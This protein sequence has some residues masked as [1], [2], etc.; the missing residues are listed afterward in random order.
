MGRRT[1]MPTRASRWTAVT[2]RRVEPAV[3]GAGGMRAAR[4]SPAWAREASAL[5]TAAAARLA[6]VYLLTR[7]VHPQAYFR[8]AAARFL[9]G[10]PADAL[11]D[12][13][14][15]C[16]PAL[17][18]FSSW[19]HSL[20]QVAK[21]RPSDKDAQAKVKECEKVVKERKFAAA[22]ANPDDDEVRPLSRLRPPAT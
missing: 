13:R 1:L 5:T 10:K 4:A 18:R 6:L 9:L 11:R 20:S 2:S 22:I 19:P 7:S 16:L 8:R 17:P 15:V 14:I 3:A 12:Y 21:M